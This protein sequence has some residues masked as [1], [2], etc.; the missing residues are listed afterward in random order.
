MA[1]KFRRFVTV[2]INRYRGESGGD[3]GGAPSTAGQAI[4]LLLAL[5]KAA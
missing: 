5:T 2:I 4:G 3:S 1:R